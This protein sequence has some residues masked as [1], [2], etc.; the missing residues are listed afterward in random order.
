MVHSGSGWTRGVQVKLWDPLRTRAIPERLRGAFT[1]RRYKNPRLP[2]LTLPVHRAI[3]RHYAQIC[4]N[5]RTLV[6]I[7]TTQMGVDQMKKTWDRFIFHCHFGWT[8]HS[9]LC[10]HI[11]KLSLIARCM[12]YCKLKT[13]IHYLGHSI[14]K[15]A[16]VTTNY[17]YKNSKYT[18]NINSYSDQLAQKQHS[19]WLRIMDLKCNLTDRVQKLTLPILGLIII[20]HPYN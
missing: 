7:C 5:N 2:Y 9:W 11:A 10:R 1:T 19:I 16:N 8:Y 14:R 12:V 6:K 18:I 13:K 3:T 17:L 4:T 15:S 20:T